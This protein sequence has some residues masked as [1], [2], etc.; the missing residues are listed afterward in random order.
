MSL[1][2]NLVDARALHRMRAAGGAFVIGAVLTAA[3]FWIAGVAARAGHALVG[4]VL[5]ATLLTLTCAAVALAAAGHRVR[6]RQAAARLKLLSLLNARAAQASATRRRLRAPAAAIARQARSLARASARLVQMSDLVRTSALAA[7]RL[8]L[9]CK[10]ELTSRFL[11][12]RP[13]AARASGA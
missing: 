12:Q 8:K 11:S 13:I 10:A 2:R 3:Q 6:A 5:P 4:F 9:G 1:I 7:Q